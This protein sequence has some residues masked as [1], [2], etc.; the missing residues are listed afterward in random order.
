MCESCWSASSALEEHRAELDAIELAGREIARAFGPTSRVRLG[1]GVR[2]LTG[3]ASPEGAPGALST[4]VPAGSV[5][6]VWGTCRWHR[7]RC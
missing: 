7:R 2:F 4:M 5:L 1:N 3:A 6:D